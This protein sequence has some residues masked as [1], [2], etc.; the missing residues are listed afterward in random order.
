MSPQP[1]VTSEG[2]IS[3][4]ENSLTTSPTT[5]QL[6]TD[7]SVTLTVSMSTDVTDHTTNPSNVTITAEERITPF[8]NDTHM[9]VTSPTASQT[10]PYHLL[11]STRLNYSSAVFSPTQDVA[12]DEMRNESTTHILNPGN[13]FSLMPEESSTLENI[14]ENYQNNS[15]N[16]KTKSGT[17]VE[18]KIYLI[19]HK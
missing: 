4:T 15:T 18:G 8:A 17:V 19:F 12:S 6:T 14:T 9:S 3:S 10:D 7:T 11:N 13:V 2:L 1:I 16:Q 5:R